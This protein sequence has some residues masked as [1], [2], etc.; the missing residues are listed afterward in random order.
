MLVLWWF[1]VSFKLSY[2]F[3][4]EFLLFLYNSCVNFLILGDVFL[5]ASGGGCI[6]VWIL[7]AGQILLESAGL[8]FK[9]DNMCG[10]V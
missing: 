8:Q 10:V 9:D 6:F 5:S 4:L 3:G 1:S 7:S 2:W